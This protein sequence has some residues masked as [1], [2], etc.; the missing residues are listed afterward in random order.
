MLTEPHCEEPQFVLH[1]FCCR[2]GMTWGCFAG[3]QVQE[4]S[5]PEVIP[6]RAAHQRRGTG[7]CQGSIRA[8]DKGWEQLGLA[9]KLAPSQGFGVALGTVVPPCASLSVRACFDPCKV[10]PCEPQHSPLPT[11]VPRH[12]CSSR[13]SEE[14]KPKTKPQWL[15]HLQQLPALC[16]LSSCS[17]QCPA[18]VTTL[19]FHL[20]HPACPQGLREGCRLPGESVLVLGLWHQPC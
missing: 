1:T 17:E 3:W 9:P 2:V 16:H 10:L 4:G 19:C 18:T 6:E 11:T 13:S 8:E 5:V 14:T 20:E 15:S 7:S 12:L